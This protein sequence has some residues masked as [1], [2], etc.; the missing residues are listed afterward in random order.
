MT[1]TVWLQCAKKW[2]KLSRPVRDE[3]FCLLLKRHFQHF[4]F[5]TESAASQ[6]RYP[7]DFKA[8]MESVLGAP[9]IGVDNT[10]PN[11]FFE[12]LCSLPT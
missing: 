2:P 10:G 7:T 12:A 6:L 9:L 5:C 1:R 3:G 11:G 4:S 8:S